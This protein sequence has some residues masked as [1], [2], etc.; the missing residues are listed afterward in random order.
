MPKF[1][2]PKKDYQSKVDI[3]HG[4]A[5]NP[6]YNDIVGVL[7]RKKGPVTVEQC[8]AC[9]DFIPAAKVSDGDVLEGKDGLDPHTGNSYA[10]CKWFGEMIR[11]DQV[12]FR[13]RKIV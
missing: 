9:P 13:P 8:A 10:T 6:Y 4:F 11:K 7:C 12:I 3:T 2:R 1:E 5:P